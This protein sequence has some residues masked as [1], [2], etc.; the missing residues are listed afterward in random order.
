MHSQL[1]LQAI[2]IPT[3][4]QVYQRII[5][6]MDLFQSMQVCTSISQIREYTVLIPYSVFTITEATISHYPAMVPF[7]VVIAYC[8]YLTPIGHLN[9]Q[10][11]IGRWV[12]RSFL[13]LTRAISLRW[14]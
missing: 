13:N 12:T 14:F 7:L 6:Q 9:S 1:P 5:V 10:S 11:T 8:L 2:P 4:H 3:T